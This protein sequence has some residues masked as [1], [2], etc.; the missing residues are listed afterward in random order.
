MNLFPGE[1]VHL[2]DW[3]CGPGTAS[4]SYCRNM[5]IGDTTFSF[6]DRSKAAENFAKQRLVEEFGPIHE[7]PA[8]PANSKKLKLISYVL[9]ELSSSQIEKLLVELQTFDGF[10]W[11]DSGAF[12]ESKLLSKIRDSLLETHYFLSPC[13]HQLGCPL[14]KPDQKKNWCH[15]FAKAPREVFHSSNWSTIAKELNMDLRSL[16]YHS[17]YAIKKTSL[18]SGIK[19]REMKTLEKR[20]LGRPRIKRHSALLD[21]CCADGEFR[22]EELNEK[23]D[24]KL[25]KSLKKDW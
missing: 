23:D 16:P 2:E 1:R 18:A 25:F 7:C 9:T 15:R 3:G 5:D 12:E 11:V 24:R 14:L 17:L 20:L 4:I 6:H 10:M 19:I 22:V 21:F 8:P 13:P